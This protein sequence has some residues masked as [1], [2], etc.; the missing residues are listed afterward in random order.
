[1]SRAIERADFEALFKLYAD[2]AVKRF[3]MTGKHPPQLFSVKLGRE[4]GTIEETY[5]LNKVAPMF[6]DGTFKGSGMRDLLQQL[7]T[8]G[9]YIRKMAGSMGVIVPDIVVQINEIWYVEP[10]ITAGEN[11]AEFRKREEAGP[12]PSERPDRKEAV[13]I[14]LHA[15]QYS[16]MGRCPIKDK[17]RRHAV[18][19]PLETDEGKLIG[20]LSMTIDDEQV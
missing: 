10:K 19:G 9:S 1:M 7:T 12:P 11:E 5:S 2:K 18:M 4:L 8:P 16:T 20:R 14:F 17:P 6:F 13:C 15:Y 3:N